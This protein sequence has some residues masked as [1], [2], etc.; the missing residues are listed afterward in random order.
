[1]EDKSS[2]NGW[3]DKWGGQV[4]GGVK[5]RKISV[6]IIVAVVNHD[7]NTI[8]TKYIGQ[9]WGGTQT[10]HLQISYTFLVVLYHS[11]RKKK[12]LQK[13]AA[14]TISTIYAS[15]FTED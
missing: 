9:L 13:L 6:R 14:K 4:G 10:I 12:T 11:F 3:M 1:M 2:L 7:K 5:K 15:V 8:H